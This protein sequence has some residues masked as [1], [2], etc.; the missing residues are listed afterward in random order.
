MQ[1]LG[2]GRRLIAAAEQV[3]R[4]NRLAIAELGV[5]KTNVAARRLYERL[6]YQ[7][8]G[9]TVEEWAYTTLDGSSR[10]ATFDEWVMQ[11]QLDSRRGREE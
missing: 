2:I 4:E 9:E 11:K 3:I 5:E 7:I 6:G 10:R 1:N 8:V